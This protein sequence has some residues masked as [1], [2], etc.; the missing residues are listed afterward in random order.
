M[1]KLALGMFY[2]AQKVLEEVISL[3]YNVMLRNKCLHLQ[4]LT[5]TIQC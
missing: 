3:L 4:L 2:F 5:M 1:F